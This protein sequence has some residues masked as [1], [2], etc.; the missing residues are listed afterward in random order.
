MADEEPK[1][2][3]TGFSLPAEEEKVLKFWDEH[4]IFEK[5]LAKRKGKKPLSFTKA[6]RP[7]T[8]GRGASRIARAFK[9]SFPL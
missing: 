2:N 1:N 8:A 7:R 9:I 6:R 3:F 4:N 5:S